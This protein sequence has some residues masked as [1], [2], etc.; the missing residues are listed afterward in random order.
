MVHGV[1]LTWGYLGETVKKREKSRAVLAIV[2]SAK[3]EKPA[4]GLAQRACTGPAQPV[5]IETSAAVEDAAPA[6][7]E[8]ALPEEG[9]A[10][11]GAAPGTIGNIG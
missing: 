6:A 7:C 3:S 11:V 2:A 10:P 1:H 4:Q 5:V 8:G 9:A